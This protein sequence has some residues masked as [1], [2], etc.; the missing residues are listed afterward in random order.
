M[1]VLT[2]P[3][4]DWL[5]IWSLVWKTLSS[6]VV[7][8]LALPEHSPGTKKGKTNS[9]QQRTKDHVLLLTNHVEPQ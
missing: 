7:Q 1:H 2:F 3:S 9:N 8:D 4:Y 5:C 6:K